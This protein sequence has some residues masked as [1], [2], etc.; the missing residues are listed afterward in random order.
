[1]V[2]INS[3]IQNII[4]MLIKKVAGSPFYTKLA[5]V[6]IS[7]VLLGYLFVLGKQILSPLVFAFLFAFVLM[8]VA[9]FFEKKV[10]MAR[11]AAAA[12]AVVIFVLSILTVLFVLGQQFSSL[13]SDWPMFQQQFELSLTSFQQWVGKTFH[14]TAIQQMA[15]VSTAT[16]KMLSASST[17]LGATVLSISSG[18]LFLVFLLIDTFFLL[19]YR[20]L[21]VR[22]LVAVFAEENA[23]MVYAVIQQVQYIIR[24]YVVGLLLQMAIISLT[25][26]VVFSVIGIKYALLLGLIT[27]LLN[28]IPYIGIFT[29]LVLCVAI[30]IGTA[31]TT[32]QLL[33]VAV[34]I[35]AIHLIDSNYLL[36]VIVGSKVKINALISLIGVIIGEMMW[37][38]SGMFL[39]IPVIAIV[40]V[41]FD[42]VASLQPWGMLLG[43]EKDVEVTIIN[44][45]DNNTVVV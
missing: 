7:L 28:V 13:S 45:V 38:I 2:A 30:S 31:A 33:L 5:M 14:I 25:A 42:R 32:T 20:S 3:F 34:A 41:V 8:P 11:G 1:M 22:F 26:V 40:K 18:L 21:L 16:D 39:A 12:L 15:Y 44:D 36:P 37:G 27:G 17:V 6:L 19:F 9:S 23:T 10:K 29:S 4:N 24:K 35:I 43:E